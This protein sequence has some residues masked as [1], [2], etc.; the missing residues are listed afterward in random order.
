[1]INVFYLDQ[2]GPAA[3]SVDMHFPTPGGHKELEVHWKDRNQYKNT[4]YQKLE[5]LGK[6]PESNS[7]LTEEQGQVVLDCKVQGCM[8]PLEFQALEAQEAHGGLGHH[9]AHGVQVA[10]KDLLGPVKKQRD[11]QKN[12]KNSNGLTIQRPN[13][14]NNIF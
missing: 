12:Q 13:N 5:C 6:T 9:G 2:E 1:M 3:A 14:T 8:V 4:I 11:V 7:V 10:L